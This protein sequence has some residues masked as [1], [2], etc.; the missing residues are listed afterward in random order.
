MMPEKSTQ[1]VAK[2][3]GK[4]WNM[5]ADMKDML[6][7]IANLQ[8]QVDIMAEMYMESSGNGNNNESED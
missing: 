3:R 2:I 8:G 5:D 6:L 7:V 4:L 1:V